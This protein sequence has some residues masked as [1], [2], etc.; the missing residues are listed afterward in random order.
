MS[1]GLG[2]VPRRPCVEMG[3]VAMG[4]GAA[5]RRC[6]LVGSLLPVSSEK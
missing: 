3:L 2:S 5:F 1:L 6:S 4:G